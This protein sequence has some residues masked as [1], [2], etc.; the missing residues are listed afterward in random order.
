VKP[1]FHGATISCDAGLFVSRE[2]DSPYCFIAGLNDLIEETRRGKNIPH[3]LTAWL[4][5]STYD[6][7]TGYEDTNN[8]AR[9]EVDPAV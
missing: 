9:V 4:R 1:E 6:R 7:L 3:S 5:Q 2:L 8:T